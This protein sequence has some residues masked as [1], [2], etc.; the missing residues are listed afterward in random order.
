MPRSTARNALP[1]AFLLLVLAAANLA[2][3]ALPDG[4]TGGEP[5]DRENPPVTGD[6]GAPS[7]VDAILRTSCYDCH[8]NETVWPWYSYLAPA[9]WL[10]AEDVE[11]GREHLNFSEWTSYESG[12]RIHKLEEAGV[13]QRRTSIEVSTTV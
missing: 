2:A 7:E 9:S 11:H 5:V 13:I 4:S 8:S 12:K 6:I 10:V 3:Q 1:V